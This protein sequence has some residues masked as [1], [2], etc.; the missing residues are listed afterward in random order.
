L[1]TKLYLERWLLALKA[2]AVR[3]GLEA[4]VR[5][6]DYK[7]GRRLALEVRQPG[8]ALE[9]RY[10]KR[11]TGA[12]ILAAATSAA[13]VGRVRELHSRLL[14]EHPGLL[15][16]GFRR[17]L[18]RSLGLLAALESAL[19][20]DVDL[21]RR[22]DQALREVK[23]ASGARPAALVRR[24]PGLRRRYEVL[25]AAAFVRG[26]ATRFVA[27]IDSRFVDL[28]ELLVGKPAP[29]PEAA[30][31]KGPASG[32]WDDLPTLAD[33]GIELLSLATSWVP[34]ASSA[35]EAGSSVPAEAIGEAGGAAVEGITEAGGAVAEGLMET[36]G[37]AAEVLATTGSC[38]S[39]AACAG[40]D[41]GGL[42]CI[43]G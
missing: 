19:A 10:R 34:D 41:C 29:R 26:P 7:G 5:A 27:V 37:A 11:R 15:E 1:D 21:P 4:H 39:D 40:I 12:R 13:I 22:L 14:A 35:G 24:Q 30:R 6:L 33:A 16:N 31:G 38:L 18:R 32:T 20:R 25:A 43:P 2:A 23:E 8:A 42:D 3:A 9:L 28:S 17:F 36:G